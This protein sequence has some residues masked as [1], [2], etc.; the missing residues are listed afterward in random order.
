MKTNKLI[1]LTII[2]FSVFIAAAF[3]KAGYE[4][5]DKVV[6]FKLK[7][8]DG[9]FVSLSDF[10]AGKGVIVIFDCNTCPYSKAYNDRII[11]L[12][13]KY[14]AKGFPV[15]TINANDP[16]KSPGDSFSEM[17]EHAKKNNYDFPYLLDDTQTVARAFGA[18]NTP[19]V[20]ILKKDKDDFIVAYTGA[21]D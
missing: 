4:V 17:V 8:T 12:N 19:H 9:K 5:G 15:I 10:K 21:I 11:S 16:E 20:F 18:T 14:A 7:N 1:I 2:S 3:I 13:K 6:D